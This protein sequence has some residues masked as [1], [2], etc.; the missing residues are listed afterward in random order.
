MPVARDR[1]TPM[2]RFVEGDTWLYAPGSM[3]FAPRAGS[4]AAP[5]AIRIEATVPKTPRRSLITAVG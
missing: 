2:I 4:S 5:Y 3:S 1:A